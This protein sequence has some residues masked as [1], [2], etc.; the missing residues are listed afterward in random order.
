MTSLIFKALFQVF[1]EDKTVGVDGK[2]R[3]PA[4]RD[5]GNRSKKKDEA[6]GMD[7]EAGFAGARRKTRL[8][9]YHDTKPGRWSSQA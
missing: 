7:R 4:M 8:L 1:L 3:K 5:N 6:K 2:F 9:Q